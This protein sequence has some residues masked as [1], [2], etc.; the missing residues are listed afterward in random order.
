M[1]PDWKIGDEFAEELLEMSDDVL[2]DINLSGKMTVVTQILRECKRIGDKVLV[3]TQR[4][5]TLAYLEE[6]LQKLNS[7]D[8]GEMVSWVL[9]YH[10]YTR[11]KTRQA[12]STFQHSTKY[13]SKQTHHH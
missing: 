8:N 13:P 4:L 1:T 11:R 10:A 6:F 7:E 2:W 5:L 9:L 3:F 12:H